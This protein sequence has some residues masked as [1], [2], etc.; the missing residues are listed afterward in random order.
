MDATCSTRL[1]MIMHIRIESLVAKCHSLA[2][3]QAILRKASLLGNKRRTSRLETCNRVVLLAG[4]T[5]Q[6]SPIS[7]GTSVSVRTSFSLN[8]NLLP[9][10]ANSRPWAKHRKE[11]L[12]LQSSFTIWAVA[13]FITKSQALGCC[14]RPSPR[15]SKMRLLVGAKSSYSPE[16]E[17]WDKLACPHKSLR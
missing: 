4:V 6:P 8:P 7:K 13:L 17:V 14:R 11:L 10:Y 2:W 3:P 9:S 16:P 15:E 5:M 12:Q 1:A